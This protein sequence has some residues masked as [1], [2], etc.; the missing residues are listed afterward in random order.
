MDAPLA[1]RMDLTRLAAAAI[2]LCE[3]RGMDDVRRLAELVQ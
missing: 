1:D 2:R 3:A